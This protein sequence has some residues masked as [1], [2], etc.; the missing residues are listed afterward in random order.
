[1]NIK[2]YFR[3]KPYWLTGGIIGVTIL[4]SGFLINLIGALIFTLLI[5]HNLSP[6]DVH[7][8]MFPF[9]IVTS[10]LFDFFSHIQRHIFTL[11]P[12]FYNKHH[13]VLL[14]QI[15]AIDIASFFFFGSII[16][17]FLGIKKSNKKKN[18]I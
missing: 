7:S 14:I 5:Y 17:L 11:P 1:M 12:Y 2:E 8:W 6:L 3:T 13:V 9:F 16:G 10:P 15:F 18:L 4:I